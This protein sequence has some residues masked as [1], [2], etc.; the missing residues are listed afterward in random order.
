MTQILEQSEEYR[1]L[2]AQTA[3]MMAQF[4]REVKEKTLAVVTHNQEE[5]MAQ[6]QKDL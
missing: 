6:Q 5:R 4:A 3:E 1:T 2:F